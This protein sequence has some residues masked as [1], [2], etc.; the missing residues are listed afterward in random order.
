MGLESFVPILPLC[1]SA[2]PKAPLSS[3]NQEE[4]CGLVC[5]FVLL[6]SSLSVSFTNV[7]V[8]V[9]I[10]ILKSCCLA[11]LRPWGLDGKSD[12]T[13]VPPLKNLCHWGFEPRM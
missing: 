8:A 13:S 6:F 4:F 9:I 2:N 5:L 10:E 11:S 1:N 3:P 12:R 7:S